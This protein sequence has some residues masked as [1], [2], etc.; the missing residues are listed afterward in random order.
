MPSK[1]MTHVVSVVVLPV[2]AGVHGRDPGD[3][4]VVLGD[5]RECGRVE[6]RPAPAK[7]ALREPL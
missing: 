5:G 2:F 4:D 1:K 3:R 6:R 7:V